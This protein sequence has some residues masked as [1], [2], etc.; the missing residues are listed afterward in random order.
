LHLVQGTSQF[1]EHLVQV[2]SM[3]LI[4]MQD[5]QVL[6]PMPPQLLHIAGM[7]PSPSQVTHETTPAP[8]QVEQVMLPA[9]VQVGH[10]INPSPPQGVQ[11]EHAPSLRSQHHSLTLPAIS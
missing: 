10:G 2:M 3:V 6:L 9:P 8:L 7:E 11:G 1:P 4:P 5:V